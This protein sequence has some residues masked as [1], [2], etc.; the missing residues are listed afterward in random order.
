MV[1]ALLKRFGMR[2]HELMG[3]EAL[4]ARYLPHLMPWVPS[5]PALP[6]YFTYCAGEKVV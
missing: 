5:A 2:L 6:P 4:A 1:R 3:A